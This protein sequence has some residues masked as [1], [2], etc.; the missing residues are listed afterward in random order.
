LRSAAVLVLAC[1]LA[2]VQTPDPTPV[3]TPA[4]S[5]AAP[6]VLSPDAMRSR[7]RNVIIAVSTVVH[8]EKSYAAENGGFFDEVR[9]LMRP[10]ECRPAL[11]A[12]T[13]PFLDAT[14]NWL[15]PKLGYTRAFHAG[16]KPSPDE[17]EKAG[18]SASSLK[19]FAY[20]ATP[21]QPGVTGTR[22][23]CGDSGGRL[24]FTPDGREPPVKD[25]RCEPCKKME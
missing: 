16:P 3:P 22:A 7:E 1:T 8:A 4:P 21:L 9:C 2:P 25:G 15:E 23:F 19:A 17:I 11:P 18:A 5:A 6:E 12:D 13:L 24:C 14:Y 20:T 10:N